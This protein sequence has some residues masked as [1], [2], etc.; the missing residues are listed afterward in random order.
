MDGLLQF[1]KILYDRNTLTKKSSNLVKSYAYI[2][3]RL[4]HKPNK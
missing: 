2:G 4:G 3:L 1:S